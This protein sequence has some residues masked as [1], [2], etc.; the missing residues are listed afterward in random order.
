MTDDDAF[1]VAPTASTASANQGATVNVFLASVKAMVSWMVGALFG[2]CLTL[3][4][5]HTVLVVVFIGLVFVATLIWFLLSHRLDVLNRR[6]HIEQNMLLLNKLKGAKLNPE[7]TVVLA[8][9]PHIQPNTGEQRG[10]EIHAGRFGSDTFDFSGLTKGYV[11]TPKW[12]ETSLEH[13]G[14]FK[15]DGRTV[16][17]VMHNLMEPRPNVRLHYEGAGEASVPAEKHYLDPRTVEVSPGY[18]SRNNKWID[19]PATNLK[20]QVWV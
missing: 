17:V 15:R 14:D 18:Y 11:C 7:E 1:A 6:W 12:Y 8:D 2:V 9:N 3:L 4:W 16:Y 20:V 10:S 5:P 19:Y 13:C